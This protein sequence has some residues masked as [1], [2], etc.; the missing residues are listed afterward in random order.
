MKFSVRNLCTNLCTCTLRANVYGCSPALSVGF[1]HLD[2]EVSKFILENSWHQG[3][4]YLR[5]TCSRYCG[6]FCA[7]KLLQDA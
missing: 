6:V 7:C 2:D 1:V 4:A 5:V 3:A